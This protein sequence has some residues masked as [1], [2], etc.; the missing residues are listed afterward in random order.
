MTPPLAGELGLAVATRESN[1]AKADPNI[2]IPCNK[3]VIIPYFVGVFKRKIGKRLFCGFE[4]PDGKCEYSYE[5]N[6]AGP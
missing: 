3:S 1:V 6:C 4:H 5:S 2:I